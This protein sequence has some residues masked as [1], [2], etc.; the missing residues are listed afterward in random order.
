MKTIITSQRIEYFAGVKE[1]RDCVDQNLISF[2]LQAGM[3]V[4]PI[5]NI[6]VDVNSVNKKFEILDKWFYNIS[7]NGIILSGGESIGTDNIRDLTELRML[8]LAFKNKIPLLGICRG[9]QVLS[10]FFGSQTIKVKNHVRTR[11]KCEIQTSDKLFPK[12]IKCYHNYAINKC[13]KNFFIT[14]M[15]EDGTIESIKHLKNNWEGW[16]WHPERDK[17]FLKCLKD[18]T[19]K[20]FK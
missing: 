7:P 16:M 10:S 19:L 4:Y 14:L 6:L 2:F 15:S 17:P 11:H 8:D 1:K 9:M 13:P 3:L 18:R 5:P 12:T 20:I